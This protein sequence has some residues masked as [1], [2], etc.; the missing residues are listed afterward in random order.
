MVCQKLAVGVS[1]CQYICPLFHE[2]VCLLSG[3]RWIIF[4][5]YPHFCL[6]SRCFF[7]FCPGIHASR[8]HSLQ[9]LDAIC[10]MISEL[11]LHFCTIP[12]SNCLVKTGFPLFPVVR[13]HMERPDTGLREASVLYF[14]IVIGLYCLCYTTV[15]KD[16]SAVLMHYRCRRSALGGISKVVLWI[17][18]FLSIVL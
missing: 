13:S 2:P 9:G 10:R 6:L 14:N 11:L 15:K 16:L 18:L 5:I 12:L 1:P 4:H 17:W 8:L 3:V 7:L